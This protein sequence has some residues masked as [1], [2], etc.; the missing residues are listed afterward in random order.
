[1]ATYNENYIS[2]KMARE[3]NSLSDISVS[4]QTVRNA[5]NEV[6]LKSVVKVKRP[7]LLPRHI[8]VGRNWMKNMVVRQKRIGIEL[9]FQMRQR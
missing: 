2:P 6:G 9:Y 1:M 3:L 5:L 8:K 7:L 4:G